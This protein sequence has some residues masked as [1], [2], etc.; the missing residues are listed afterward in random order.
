MTIA[1][2]ASGH[3]A[4][5]VTLDGPAELRAAVAEALDPYLEVVPRPGLDVRGGRRGRCI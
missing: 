2:T 1:C 3:R 4:G 5:E